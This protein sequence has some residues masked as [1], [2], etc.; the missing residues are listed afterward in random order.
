MHK[1]RVRVDH[2]FHLGF[3]VC[4]HVH[5]VRGREVLENHVGDL[6]VHRVRGHQGLDSG[7]RCGREHLP[8][9]RRRKILGCHGGDD[10]CLVPRELKFALRLLVFVPMR[11]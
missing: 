10:V 8:V 7:G 6:Y 3:R 11:L 4:E 5:A 2:R 1:V 9:V